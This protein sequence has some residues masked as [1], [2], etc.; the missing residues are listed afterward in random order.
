MTAFQATYSDFK[1][2]KGRKVAQVILEVPLEAADNALAVLGGVPRPDAEVWVGVAL[3][4]KKAVQEPP[5]KERK[6]FHELPLPQQA[7][8]LCDDL[9]FQTWA[10]EHCLDDPVPLNAEGARAYLLD[11]CQI[12]SRAELSTNMKA[13]DAFRYIVD[14][15]RRETGQETEMRG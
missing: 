2:V 10:R 7:G 11:V 9:R 12:S 5:Q 6:P 4:D 3:L 13:E 15:Y 14:R 1:I 8:I